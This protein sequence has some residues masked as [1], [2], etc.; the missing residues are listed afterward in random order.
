MT[1]IP[2]IALQSHSGVDIIREQF[3]LLETEEFE[4]PYN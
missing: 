4:D 3:H 2:F 1:E